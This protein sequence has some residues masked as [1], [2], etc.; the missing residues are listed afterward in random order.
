MLSLILFWGGTISVLCVCAHESVWW[1]NHCA[2]SLIVKILLVVIGPQFPRMFRERLQALSSRYMINEHETQ[3]RHSH[4][5]LLVLSLCLSPPAVTRRLVSMYARV[6][7]AVYD[8]LS[9]R[10]RGT[11]YKKLGLLFLARKGRGAQTR[12]VCASPSSVLMN[13]NDMTG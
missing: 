13:H 5:A 2:T 7:L 8:S 10:S 1:L 4:L 3:G 12:G 9:R 11:C 6:V